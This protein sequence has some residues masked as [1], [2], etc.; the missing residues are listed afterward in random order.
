MVTIK[1]KGMGCQ[2]CIDHVTKALENIPG[3]SQIKVDLESG[4]ASFEQSETVT[5][6]EISKAIDAAGYEVEV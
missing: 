5:M 6:N 4:T 1:V 2:N 3:I